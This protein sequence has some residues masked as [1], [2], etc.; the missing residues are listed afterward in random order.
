MR[1]QPSFILLAVLM[2]QALALPA[3]TLSNR[4]DPSS[5][6]EDTDEPQKVEFGGVVAPDFFVAQC[7]EGTRLYLD[8][9]EV[10]DFRLVLDSWCCE[11][12]DVED[13]EY[14]PCNSTSTGPATW[15]ADDDPLAECEARGVGTAGTGKD[16][17]EPPLN[18]WCCDDVPNNELPPCDWP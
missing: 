12:D 4:V 6:V 15:R 9:E 2:V 17:D 11:E 18:S 13:N 7:P 14:P 16:E 10:G 1:K 3:C 5:D 8:G